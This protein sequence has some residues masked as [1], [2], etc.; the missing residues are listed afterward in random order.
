MSE[1]ASSAPSRRNL[2]R[3]FFETP[4]FQRDHA[5]MPSSFRGR[6]IADAEE[7]AME[8]K[9]LSALTEAQ[10]RKV[11]ERTTEAAE[12]ALSAAKVAV[13]TEVFAAIGTVS[14]LI[15][16]WISW[17]M[18]DSQLPKDMQVPDTGSGLPRELRRRP[19]IGRAHV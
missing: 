9:S 16:T 3:V 10:L 14:G 18:D 19:Q 5:S 8:A 4:G 6:G 12:E 2:G 17:Q 7:E 11:I 1:L 13:W 15:T